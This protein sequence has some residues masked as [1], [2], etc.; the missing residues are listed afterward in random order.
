MLIDLAVGNNGW[1][2]P[3][4]QNELA[5]R[6]NGEAI[7]IMFVEGV[8]WKPGMLVESLVKRIWKLTHNGSGRYQ[9][10]QTAQCR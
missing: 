9:V 5:T 4:R 7:P 1:V 10:T 6:T 8:L 2:S 3:N